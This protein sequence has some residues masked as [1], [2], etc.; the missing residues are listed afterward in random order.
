MIKMVYRFLLVFALI[1]FQFI[2]SQE[3]EQ[4]IPESVEIIDN[5]LD[6]FFT[7]EDDI[8]VFHEKESEIIHRD[9]Y[10]IKANKNQPYHILLSCGMSALPMNVPPDTE[11]AEYAEL[12]F[13]LPKEWNLNYES[14]EDEKNYWPVRIMKEIMIQP[15][16]GKSWYGF[17]HT[18]G[19][20][21]GEEFTDGI[22]FNSVM[23]AYS[24]ELKENFTT[25]LTADGKQIQI[26]TLIPLYKEE[27][28]YKRKY[29]V[30]KLLERFDKFGIKEIVKIG[31]RNVCR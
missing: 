23:L 13:L 10:F 29:G 2:H 12:M 24:T 18:F 31:R 30:R 11:S 3:T 19:F 27:L 6:K 21:D 20:D 17:G 16:E 26:Y 28:A 25:L 4:N 9:I 22:G 1:G 15:H 7:D 8:V 14:F 5:H